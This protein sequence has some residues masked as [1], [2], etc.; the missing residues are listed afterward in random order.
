MA[1]LLDREILQL[2]GQQLKMVTSGW[3]KQTVES[4]L[5][6]RSLIYPTD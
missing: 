3:G 1:E 5:L 4:L 2:S 6:K